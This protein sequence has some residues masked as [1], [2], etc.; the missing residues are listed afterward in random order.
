MTNPLLERILRA[1]QGIEPLDLLA[2]QLAPTD[3]QSLLLEVYRRRAARQTPATLLSSYERSPLVRP[4][5]VNPVTLLDVDRLAFSLAAPLFEPVELAP[6]CPLGTNS[7]VASVD[8]NKTIAT[9]RN[10]E[11]VSDSTNVLALECAVRRRAHLR[12][13][14]RRHQRVRLCASH[15]L[16]R[17]QSFT[18][19]ASFAH[20]RLFAVCTA[21]RDEGSYRFELD[22]LAEQLAVYLRLFEQLRQAGYGIQQ[23][24]VAI[25]DL[26]DGAD[27]A[28]MR[29]DV[30]AALAGQFAQVQWH[31]DPDRSA[32]RN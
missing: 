32:G 9:I 18:G 29:S 5:P 3:L 10:T 17:P 16:L 7:V 22:A 23:V 20:F 11:L 1:S 15:R 19:P 21:G 12:A 6:I 2:E 14:N 27:H 28:V 26:S 13:P 25:T 31:A 30:M 24:R 4:S 8:Q